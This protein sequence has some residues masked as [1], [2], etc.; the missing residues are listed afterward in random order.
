V[1][2]DLTCFG[3]IVVATGRRV[4]R[5]L[6]I[7]QLI[8]PLIVYQAGTLSGNPLAMLRARRRCACSNQACTMIE[9]LSARAW[10]RSA[11]AAAA[12]A[13]PTCNRVG[14]MLTGFFCAN[15]N[16]RR[17]GQAPDT[18]AYARFFHA[19]LDRGVYLALAIRSRFVSL[20]HTESRP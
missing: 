19:M 6:E 8:S 14:S 16:R 17:L 18:G 1:T 2:P 11:A 12:A 4:R 13:C 7:T 10:P 20:A 3:K 9:T 15:G 5:P